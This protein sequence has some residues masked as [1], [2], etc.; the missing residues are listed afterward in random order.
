VCPSSFID[1]RRVH[2]I[3][4]TLHRS[5]A[6]KHGHCRVRTSSIGAD[7]GD[8]GIWIYGLD[9]SFIIVKIAHRRSS[10][11]A[12]H[13]NFN[14]SQIRSFVI[15]SNNQIASGQ[16]IFFGAINF[17]N[18]GAPA[19]DLVNAISRH[20]HKRVIDKNSPHWKARPVGSIHAT[21]TAVADSFSVSTLFYS[22]GCFLHT[23]QRKFSSKSSTRQQ[24]LRDQSRDRINLPS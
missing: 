6:L 14:C 22:A 17:I 21:R 24:F 2:R 15:L 20:L 1:R 11:S 8:D 16:V 7:R 5:K 3:P 4:H 12:R 9:G 23:R 10:P 18:N 13:P 19:Y